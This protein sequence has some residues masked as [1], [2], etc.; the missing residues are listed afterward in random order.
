MALHAFG[1]KAI[2]VG[3]CGW[4]V[5]AALCAFG[6][7]VFGFTYLFSF[8]FQD[9]SKASNAVLTLCLF[10]SVIF[11]TVLFVLVM[12]NYDPT[13]DFPSACDT[14]TKKYPEGHC[15][16]P[17]V[18]EVEKILG[19]LFRMIPSVCLYQAL[20][21]IAC[22]A[23][24]RAL[25]PKEMMEAGRKAGLPVPHLSFSPWAYEWAG[26]PL[27]YLIAEAVGFFFLVLIVDF[28]LSSPRLARYFD[29]ASILRRL[30]QAP[31][32]RSP[33]HGS[34]LIE[35]NE[36]SEGD[37]GVEAECRRV[38]AITPQDAAL[39][40]EQLEKTYRH[41]TCTSEAKHAVRGISIAVHPGE[42]FG[43]LGHN[44]AGKTSALRCMTGELCCT[45][46]RVYVGGFDVEVETSRARTL[47]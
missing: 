21:S 41:W 46:G 6:P 11:S 22:V 1:F 31:W 33:R 43:L 45:A 39:H 9:H 32:R 24:I 30:P 18:R 34:P 16:V 47:R 38:A 5:A 3:D 10:G 23:D 40:I 4:A 25:V 20:F 17:K 15:R 28:C 27:R 13:S 29:A 12:I 36:L 7:A 8:L 42:V 2:L 26:E 19:P 44:G 14:P 37:D 35:S